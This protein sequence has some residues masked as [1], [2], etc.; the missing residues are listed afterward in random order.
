MC[1]LALCILLA[2]AVR[3]ADF[4]PLRPRALW[5]PDPS[6]PRQNVAWEQ[7]LENR[8]VRFLTDNQLN[9]VLDEQPGIARLEYYPVRRKT[10]LK[11]RLDYDLLRR[12]TKLRS[13]A[14]RVKF[15]SAKPKETQYRWWPHKVERVWTTE[16]WEVR[17]EIA[18]SGNQ[19][20]LRYTP[21]WGRPPVARLARPLEPS[22]L[23]NGVC[24]AASETPTS[25]RIAAGYRPRD[26][27]DALKSDA[28]EEARRT[29]DYY[30]TALVPRLA[31]ANSALDRLYYYLFYVVRSSLVDV[32]FEPFHHAYTCPWKTSA[33]YQWSWNTPMN[34]IAERWLNDPSLAME[35]IRLIADNHGALNFGTYIHPWRRVSPS[36][37]IFDW[38]TELD[39]AQKKLDSTDYQYLTVM[40]YTVPNSFLGIWEVY[41]MTGDKQFLRTCLPEMARYEESARRRARPG[42]VLT[43]YQIMVDEYDYSL[44]WKPVQ[45]GFT[46]G[47]LLR[48]FDV[49]IL[50]PD[51]N[52]YMSEL[53]VILA[54]AYGELGRPRE[55]TQMEQLARR[56]AEEVNA[57]LWDERRKF[58]CDVRSD[59]LT[60][61]S[62]RAVSGFA[63][64]YARIAT[65]ERRGALLEAL[66]DPRAFGSP[67]PLPSVE[68]SH[69]D[70]DPNML[71]YGGDSLVTDGV[72][73]LVN[74]LVRNGETGR[75]AKMLTRAIDMV[76][77]DGVSSSYSYNAFT[78]RPNQN[79][80]QLATQCAI[81]IDLISRY[82]VGFTPSLDGR[83]QFHPIA[84]ELAGGQLNYGPLRYK[85]HAVQAR[86][87]GREWIITV[88]GREQCDSPRKA[89]GQTLQ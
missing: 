77:R 61:T 73:V 3:A 45:T 6:L 83:I 17:E 54:H 8:E 78:A 51:F 74:A 34:A 56:T 47:G 25:I 55:A 12:E 31:T 28:F 50:M 41:L 42:S 19:V 1:G 22:C 65:P 87:A 84:L 26:A 44:R 68:L 89:S 4:E 36:L 23:D 29:W 11:G 2:A 75:A 76:N 48:T 33:I 14:G 32:P 37:D 52:S 88:D 67:Y 24:L 85:G 57:R 66:D 72:W 5:K 58:Y 43:P 49:P 69:P 38:Y 82:V 46:K 64:L 9:A 27:A 70:L 63:P 16:Q 53:R 71:T 86:L 13:P 60:S 15:G 7:L 40:P 59:T 20:A 39:R 62:V 21:L 80:H 35:G 81:L 30:F 18:V 79:K 10:A